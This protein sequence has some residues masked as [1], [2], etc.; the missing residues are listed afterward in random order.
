MPTFLSR[1]R[2]SNSLR[3]FIIGAFGSGAFSLA[4]GGVLAGEAAAPHD[5]SGFYLGANLGA[6]LP[7]N[8]HERLQAISGLAGPDFDLTP[9]SQ[10]R[11]GVSFG[12]QTGYNWQ[13][14]A[15]V[16]GVE[17]DLNFLDGR[18]GASGIFAA[19]AAYAGQG[20]SLYQLAYSP[21]ARFFGSLRARLGFSVDRALFYVTAGAAT[22]GARGPAILQLLPGGPG[23]PYTTADSQSSRMKYIFGAGVDYALM[24][25]WSARLE[26]LFLNQQLNSQLFDNGAGFQYVSRTRNENH[27]LRFGLN[28]NFGS[29]N[30]APEAAPGNADPKA[31]APERYSVHGQVTEIIQ[32]YP[33]YRAH[34]VGPA[35]FA[36]TSGAARSGV[37]AN[38]FLGLRLWDGGEAYINPEIDQGYALSQAHG[39]ANF[40]NGVASKI[41]RGAPYLRVQRYFL[42][43]TIGLGGDAEV[44]GAGGNQ[45]GGTVDSN[46]LTFTVGKVSFTDFFDDN[47]YAHDPQAGFVN[48][49]IN[50]MGAIDY[51]SDSWGYTHG[52]V[53]DLK[54]GDWSGRAGVFQQSTVPNDVKIDPKIF[55]QFMVAGEIERRYSL[56]DQPG[57]IKFIAFLDSGH[58]AN[59]GDVTTLALATGNLPP[60]PATLRPRNVKTGGG[61][62][63]EQQL[64]PWLGAFLRAS[65]ADGRYETVDF[66]D[67][68]RSVATG[69]V[70]SGSV[71]GRDKDALGLGAVVS[72]ISGAEQR[73]YALGGQGAYVGDGALSYGGE[74]VF[75]TYYKFYIADGMHVTADYQLVGNPAY[76][77]DRG[78]MSFFGLRLH[79]E[80]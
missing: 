79:A 33:K 76:N 59:L 71:W 6:G 16:Y 23:N 8:A 12:A 64:T 1:A 31:A 67:I 70:V 11:A 72:G 27:I 34:Y 10:E 60:D 15:W 26:Y 24:D 77:R 58:F 62:N 75:E 18:N 28:Y 52:A 22:G 45:L 44:I 78:P 47:K 29:D 50:I 21:S 65:I 37:V 73:F 4:P 57:K 5:W 32:G 63:I 9:P 35:S 46:R 55:N 61:V 74:Q 43:Q 39:A 51:A 19:P 38:V 49:T 2:N 68:Q 80:F 41:G 53:A 66:A 17:T 40:P 36:P 48:T 25:R 20:A 13:L 42:R 3:A 69:V 54:F 30:T 14:G 56:F 7:L